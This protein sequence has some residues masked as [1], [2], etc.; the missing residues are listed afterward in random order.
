MTA[1]E[2]ERALYVTDGR[3]ALLYVNRAFRDIFGYTAEEALGRPALELLGQNRLDARTL[4]RLT[5]QVRKGRTFH[6]EIRAFDKH[7]KELW[8]LA[9]V[10]PVRGAD[11]QV[12]NL[13]CS[14]E[15]T[16]ESRKIQTLQRDVLEA[17]AQDMPL[18]QVADLICRRVE[19][20]FPETVCSIAAV[21]PEKRLRPLAN[22]SLPDYYA[23]ALDGVP[24]GPASGTCGAAAH[25]GEPVMSEDIATDPLW[26]EL[27]GAVLP[28]GLRAC[29]SSP[30]RLRDGRVAGT[31]AFYFRAPRLPGP[32][33][34]VVLSAC[35]HLCVVAFERHEAKSRINR[36]A[37]YDSLTGLPNRALLRDQ[38]DDAFRNAPPGRRM[39]FLFLDIDNFKDVNDTLGHPVGDEL[40]VEIARR[41]RSQL[42]PGD[43]VSRHGGDEFVI[44]LDDCD[45]DRAA[46][47]A[48]GILD[49]LL[50]PVH[51]SGCSLPVTAS[52]GISLYPEDG[53]DRDTLLKNADAAMYQ[54]KADNGATHRFFN[55][56]MNQ[57]GQDR[58][59]LGGALREAIA[60]RGLQLR[61][62][63]L[64]S[65]RDGRLLGVEALARW[66]HPTLGEIVPDRFIRLAEQAGLI[67]AIGEW[68]LEEACAQLAAWDGKGLRVP[69]VSV[70]ISP[71]HFRNRQLLPVVA[72]ALD[73]H[74]LTPRR[75]LI[76]I[77]EGV[78]VGDCPTALENTRALRSLGIRLAMDDFGTGSSSLSHLARLPVTELKVDR[79]FIA[80]IEE[81]ENARKLVTAVIRIGQGLGLNV[82]AEGVETEAQR[83]FLQ[84]LDC[85]AMQGF[86]VARA[87]APAEFETW[88]AARAGRAT[89]SGPD[90]VSAA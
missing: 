65:A 2:T 76:E 60:R 57:A 5:G 84:A 30:I 78:V 3:G 19:Q 8:M 70:N 72:A 34:E 66:T 24:I 26:A 55:R 32:W 10:R 22:P 63:P 51:I 23:Q 13:V 36:L 9:T 43:L 41:L 90:T 25:R 29:W 20:I 64:V 33:H 67:E 83:R 35:L 16:T 37:Y 68:A 81:D 28:L 88:L 15:N 71:V 45:A 77:T 6:E 31:F 49:A 21:D 7:G 40:L 86:L 73:R 62:Q 27:S 69:Y 74:G 75:L 89:G 18:R 46:L 39:A 59:L 48:D 47:T 80:G 82:I 50:R 85:D 61:Y 56:Q 42:A 4:E 11:G 52:I 44:M 58:L 38:I 17:V 12:D 1:D 14:L 79:H 87:L 54:A 53:A